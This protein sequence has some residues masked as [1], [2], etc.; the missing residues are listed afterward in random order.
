MWSNPKPND[1]LFVSTNDQMIQSD[2]AP[3]ISR[4]HPLRIVLGQFAP[5]YDIVDFKSY[6]RL[7]KLEIINVVYWHKMTQNYSQSETP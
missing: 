6:F 1:T 7:S 2:V 4:S 3:P 5:I